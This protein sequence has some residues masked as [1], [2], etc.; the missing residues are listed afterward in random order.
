MLDDGTKPAG[1]GEVQVA[2]VAIELL[3]A[4]AQRDRV[5]AEFP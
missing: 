3:D 5:A 1:H 4:V 2:A